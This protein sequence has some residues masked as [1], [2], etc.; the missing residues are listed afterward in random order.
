MTAKELSQLYH[1]N[2]EIEQ[3]KER[4]S[5][6]V[7]KRDKWRS[8][9]SVHT[10]NGPGGTQRLEHVYYTENS[11]LMENPIAEEVEALRLKIKENLAKCLRERQRL[12]EYISGV[13]DSE[14]RQILSL[15]YISGLPWAQ[16]AAHISPY[17]TADSVR[18][19]HNRF[20]AKDESCS[21]CSENVW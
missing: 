21:F 15:R 10:S 20:L 19:A 5:Q 18:I 9:S 7:D 14:M 16:V 8:C 4:L 1:L 2:R 3:Q 17:A 12:E 13:D 6:L 11:A